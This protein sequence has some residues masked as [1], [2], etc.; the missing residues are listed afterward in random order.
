MIMNKHILYLF[1]LMGLLSFAACTNEENPLFSNE[2]GEVCF[3]VSEEEPVQIETR[4]FFD[5]NDFTVNLKRGSE[6]LF[7]NRKYSDIAGTTYSYP[8]GDGYLFTA[9][10]CTESEAES[11]NSKWGKARATG[12]TSFE[13]IANQNNDIKVKCKQINTSVQVGFSDFIKK[14]C[15]EYA[16]TFYAADDE[17]RQFTIDQNN[18]SYKTAY[19][20]VN[21]SRAL[22]Y[23]VTLTRSGEKHV[24]KGNQTL[25]PSS[26]YQLNI[27]LK[28]ES[29]S[30]ISIGIS[31]N[32]ELVDDVTM[33]PININPYNPESITQQP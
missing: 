25:Y 14:L 29:I 19:F 23:T 33:D 6:S 16:I 13:V 7:S 20:N 32:G 9:E 31:V 18:Y 3:A 27:K 17:E 24:F 11:A 15:T 30:V 10:S 28:D 26:N 12:E 8:A 5:V 1:S 2:T 21:E 22:N 4:A